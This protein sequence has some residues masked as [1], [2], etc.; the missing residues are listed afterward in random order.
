MKS[1]SLVIFLSIVAA[2]FLLVYAARAANPPPTPAAE[3]EFQQTDP[4]ADLRAAFEQAIA[5]E[6]ALETAALYLLYQVQVDDLQQSADRQWATADLVLKSPEGEI[7]P[8]EA[9]LAL[10]RYTG[11][12][13]QVTMPTDSNWLDLLK[14][15]P[16]D[17]LPTAERDM[18]LEL[19]TA[20]TAAIP[21]APIGGYLLPW[22]GGK[23]AFLSRSVAHDKDIPSGNAHFSFDFYN[24][25]NRMF[26]VYA[27]KN[28][29]VWLYKDDV[30]TCTEYHCDQPLG[31]YI[32]LQDTS[33]SP[34]TYQLY[35]HLAQ[36]SIPPALKTRGVA[37]SQGQRIATVDN[38]GQSWGHHLH[39]QVHT[40]PNSYWGAA[41]DITFNDVTI[42][43][44]RPRRHDATY[45]DFPWCKPTDVCISGQAAYVSGNIERTDLTPPTG[46]LFEP[47]A[48]RTVN[49]SQ[50]YLE[51]WALDENTT[52]GAPSGLKSAQFLA[53]Y[54]D[55]WHEV[56]APF[57]TLLFNFTWNWC[58]AAVP[59]GP[60]TFGL[61]LT[62]NANNVTLVPVGARPTLKQFACP[63]VPPPPCPPRPDQVALFSQ[64][65]FGGACMILDIGQYPTAAQLAA[66]GVTRVA[67]LQVG[68]LV[69]ATLYPQENY[70]GNAQTF[71]ADDRNLQDNRFG[72][73]TLA[74]LKIQPRA[75]AAG[76]PLGLFPNGAV[77]TATGSSTSVPLLARDTGGA[78]LWEAR[79]TGGGA[80]ITLPQQDSPAFLTNALSP[81]AYQ[82]QARARAAGGTW[83]NWSAALPLTVIP[84][85][86]LTFTFD[87]P[88]TDSM[89]IPA[90][91]R[92]DGAWDFGET[93]GRDGKPT[94]RWVA[95]P[96][97]PAFSALTSPLIRLPAA[98]MGLRFT[99]RDQAGA[100][101]WSQRR[102]EISGNGGT[103]S[104]LLSL[105]GAQTG[106]WVQSPLMDLSA[107]AGQS[108]RIKFVFATFNG[109]AGWEVDDFEIVP[110]PA[111]EVCAD[112]EDVPL[113]VGAPVAG[114]LC[115]AGDVD[116]FRFTGVEGG[117][118][119]LDVDAYAKGSP[120][121]AFLQVFADDGSLLAQQDDEQ[122][123][124]LPDPRLGLLLPYTGGY[125]AR[126]KAFEHPGVGGAAF[127]YTLRLLEDSTPP[128][129]TLNPVMAGVTISASQTTL[130]AQ[131][132]DA[133][134]GVQKVVFW[135][136][137]P[138]WA[139]GNWQVVAEDV[140]GADG[141]QA[142]FDPLAWGLSS[143]EGVAFFAQAFDWAGNTAVAVQWDVLLDVTP[144]QTVLAP[145]PATLGSTAI[146]LT[147]TG[148]DDLSG[149]VQY[150]LQVQVGS[151]GWRDWAVY[152]PPQTAD[153]VIGVP[154]QTWA[155][156][157]RGRD[158]MGNREDFPAQPEATVTLQACSAPDAW[159]NTP[160]RDDARDAA[161]LLALGESQARNLCV[162]GD[163]DWVKI[164]AQAGQVYWL[165]GI[166]DYPASALAFRLY[167]ADGTTLLGMSTA[168]RFGDAVGL[169]WRAEV[170]ATYF[171]EV[172]HID[173]RVAGD[174]VAY[175]LRLQPGSVLFLPLLL[176]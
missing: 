148:S 52:G 129:L 65:N 145:L 82:W 41:V 153:W 31:N 156:R 77:F 162:P 110:L 44:G 107:Y 63:F 3:V 157:L 2:V 99:F 91:W 159:D 33:T 120:L 30:P 135:W 19:Y 59:D 122:T 66:L 109:A 112:A 60:V 139:A 86:P 48:Y 160:N 125:V 47:T 46:D 38:T 161:G 146:P 55:S 117:R 102:V 70:G 12:G 79:L 11:K 67:S 147:W 16:E 85:A 142:V 108:I 88:Y 136:H 45:D 131:A 23:T 74:S 130:T 165:R 115:P 104:P 73:Q 149:L 170:S 168:E 171:V 175:T 137:A 34:T 54:A 118:V 49:A 29:V 100:D 126:L 172:K 4:A 53:F 116:T 96:Q 94:L 18:W 25:A 22:E 72:V 43:G 127:T 56:G 166:P 132:S 105:S 83:S 7:L 13:W 28:G 111:P 98:P 97:A 103:F 90:R 154:G 87:A 64:E 93:S 42:N 81:A 35:L 32:V 174:A 51:G 76:I 15:M 128:L 101:A 158:A 152:F 140:N 39:F 78:N 26:P 75:Q 138:N 114:V 71:T 57:S 62:D 36:G 10:A 92:A 143:Q 133:G 58:D 69:A 124:I 169:V 119:L 155:F 176:R 37:V 173:P 5:R 106:Y 151:D 80:T 68:S 8:A 167:A 1:R 14:A 164:Q 144:P 17:V 27:A 95:Q 113:P 150:D 61:R 123:G 84:S 6:R 163:T 121:D 134:S 40:N 9:G 24:P 50:I 89:D 21:A 20:Q 141:W